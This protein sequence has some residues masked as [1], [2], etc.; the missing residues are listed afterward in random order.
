MHDEDEIFSMATSE[1]YS[2]LIVDIKIH[3]YVI[4]NDT[5]ST[6]QHDDKAKKEED[7]LLPVVFFH[8]FV[9]H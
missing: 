7:N 6:D 8:N 3:D 4:E 9:L 1:E 2:Q 5:T